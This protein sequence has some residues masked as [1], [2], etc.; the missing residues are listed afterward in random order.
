MVLVGAMALVEPR[1]FSR[2]NIINILRN[3]SFL[4]MIAIGQM[5]VMIVGGFD[6]CV[7]AVMA[8]A[9]VS[10][11]MT[12]GAALVAFP[13]LPVWLVCLAGVMVALGVGTL[14]G[15][16]NGL[17]VIGLRI[18]PFMGTLG[19]MSALGGLA[20]FFTRGVPITTV[21]REFVSD[22]GRGMWLGLP[23]IVWIVAGVILL[24][25]WV[26]EQTAGG[27][28]LYAAGGNPQAARASGIASGR[29]VTS[30]Y[31]ASGLLAAG[32]GILMTARVGSGQPILG[33]TAAIESIAAAVLGGVSLR[34][35][36]GRVTR[37][38]T[39]ALFLAILSNVLN[40]ARVDSKWQTL[41][42]GIAVILAVLIELKA[43]RRSD[44]E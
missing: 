30:A 12:M 25:W 5:L 3:F 38:V 16:V 39:A 2:L 32:A 26:M 36:I 41:I 15:L 43:S 42:L 7:G 4:S 20:L 24:A 34:G 23:L 28:H 11:A 19:M 35:G 33:S 40:L 31:M 21:P 17:L 13:D 1:F 29:V 10:G 27:R 14:A 6:M 9:S 18:S 8:L 22:L 44:N 37:V